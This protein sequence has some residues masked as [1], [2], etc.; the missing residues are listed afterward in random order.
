VF[1]WDQPAA[2]KANATANPAKLR[3]VMV[4]IIDI[5]VRMG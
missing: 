2:A 1:P 3:H 5:F 4:G